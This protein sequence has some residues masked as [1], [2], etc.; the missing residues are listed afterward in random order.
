MTGPI[1]ILIVEDNVSVSGPLRVY[2][3]AK[4]WKSRVAATVDEAA[5]MIHSRTPKCILLD[6]NLSIGGDGATLIPVIR[7]ELPDSKI[8][9]CSGEAREMDGL[10]ADAVYVKAFTPFDELVAQ[11]EDAVPKGDGKG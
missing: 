1:Q 5:E 9:I 10:G 11:I 6:L 2:L 8:I 3:E 7:E 4:G